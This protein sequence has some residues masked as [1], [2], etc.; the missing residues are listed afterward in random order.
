MSN[1]VFPT[2]LKGLKW[3]QAKTPIFSTRIQKSTSGRSLRAALY[4][5]PIYQYDL[6]YEVLRDTVALNELQTLMGFYLSR[7]GAFDSFL[8]IDPSDNKVAGQAIGTGDTVTAAFQLVRT[9]GGFAEPCLDIQAPGSPLPV[10]NV[11]V[12]AVLQDPSYY[13]I[14]ASDGS[15]SY[16][17]GGLLTFGIGHIPGAAPITADFSYYKR[18]CFIEYGEGSGD[19]FS[20]FMYNLWEL[21]KLSLETVR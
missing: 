3:D 7:Q 18:V 12:N 20:Q 2:T 15:T 1:V 21:K 6:S 5:Y 17:N 16:F 11:Y 13:S 19:S 4:Q 8:Y 14:K 10:L 9:Y